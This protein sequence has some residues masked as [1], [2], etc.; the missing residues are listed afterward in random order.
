VA[1]WATRAHV[2]ERATRRPPPVLDGSARS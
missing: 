1:L 2:V